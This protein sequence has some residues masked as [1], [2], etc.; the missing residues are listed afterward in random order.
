MYVFWITQRLFSEIIKPFHFALEFYFIWGGVC[1]FFLQ[2]PHFQVI[3]FCMFL[4]VFLLIYRDEC[5]VWTL[6][7]ALGSRAVSL[8]FQG[9]FPHLQLMKPRAEREREHSVLF[10]QHQLQWRE[11]HLRTGPFKTVT[12]IS[13]TCLLVK[14]THST[15]PPVVLYFETR[16][17]WRSVRKPP[18]MRT[19]AQ[20]CS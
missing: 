18:S 8:L 19:E 2:T 12:Q 16:L 15:P 13:S 4:G 3:H 9:S 1:L 17:L 20:L 6:R 10:K 7:F 14:R 5:V 11:K